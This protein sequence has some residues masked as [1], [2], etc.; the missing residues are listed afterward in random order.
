MSDERGNKINKVAI[1]G[2]LAI[3]MCFII[4]HH[5]KQNEQLMLDERNRNMEMRRIK[6]L[7]RQEFLH[8]IIYKIFGISPN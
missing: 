4:G 5:S 6:S 7:R 3:A 2:G 1:A 8:N